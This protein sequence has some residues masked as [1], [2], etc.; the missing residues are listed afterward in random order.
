MKI[1][2]KFLLGSL[3]TFVLAGSIGCVKLDPEPLSFY[4]PEN[5]FTDQAG[6][7]SAL[8]TCRK[9]Q[10][11]EF[12]GDAFDAGTCRTP[13]V[14]EYAFSDMDVIGSPETKEIHNLETQLTPTSN[15]SLYMRYWLLGWDGITYANTVI[16]NVPNATFE[17]E[18]A[19]NAILA[20]GYFHRAYWYY[21]LVNEFGDVPLS[22]DEVTTP[23]LDFKTAS[24]T[25]ILK[26]MKSDME[27]AVQWLPITVQPGQVNRAAGEHMLAKIDLALG[28][29]QDAIDAATRC[30]ENYGNHLM[31]SRFGVNANVDSLD[32]FNDLFNPDNISASENKEGLYVVQERY[33][34][35]GNGSENG[36]YRMRNLVPYWSNGS[37]VKTPDGKQGTTYD[38]S[39]YD[40]YDEVAKLGR[41]IA[42]IRP[43]NY[44]QY[45]VWANSGTDMR[46]NSNNW[47]DKSRL[48]YNRPAAKGGSATWFGKPIQAAFVS[49]TIRCYFSFP[50][51]KVLIY[52]DDINVGGSPS[53]GYTDSYV[54]RLAETYLIRA[55]AYWWLNNIPK[56]T[57]DVNTIRARANA[58]LL[59]NVTIDDIFDERARELFLEEHR[60]SELTRVAFLMAQEGKNGYSISN[61]SEKNWY[62]DRVMAKNNFYGT[63]YFYSTNSYVMKPYHVLWPI[64]E[65]WILANS[66]GHINQNIG[67]PGAEN[68]VAPE[69]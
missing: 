32:V 7:E 5:V 34:I 22:L 36:S 43:S 33:G 37:S 52:K 50:T 42:K 14:Y 19:K 27:F 8:V 31:T 61:F 28:D 39:P 6:L 63:Q 35:T 59:S 11:V 41:G 65:N 2:Y 66:E 18:E 51:V 4:A 15:Y 25:K 49:D 45:E 48:Y 68:N 38:V 67:Y 1:R 26:Q 13:I 46:H 17:S 3:T 64:P 10:K 47:F 58:P 24:R 16:S 12:V 30:I 56:A 55:E 9:Q 53:G 57:E 40:G 29:F 69:Q 54:F 20:E 62:Y 23:K 60:K 44:Y 21:L